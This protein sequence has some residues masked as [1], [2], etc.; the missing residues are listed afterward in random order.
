MK[1]LHVHKYM[2]VD[3]EWEEKDGGLRIGKG[4]MRC[5]G[6]LGDGVVFGRFLFFSC[7]GKG[8]CKTTQ[9]KVSRLIA[10]TQ[11]QEGATGGD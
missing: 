6:R 8:L 4:V 11:D 1:Y 3:G 2:V 5:W 9:R 10:P 7:W